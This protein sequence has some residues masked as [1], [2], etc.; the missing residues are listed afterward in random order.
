MKAKKKKNAALTAAAAILAGALCLCILASCGEKVSEGAPEKKKKPPLV[1][2][3]PVETGGIARTVRLPGTIRPAIVANVLSSAEGKITSLD[4]REGDYVTKDAVIGRISPSV[5]EDILN[6][7]RL[8]NDQD[9]NLEFALSQYRE[10]PIVAPT[11]GVVAVRS[12]QPGD[13]VV[14]RQKLLE[15]QSMCATCLHVEI[16]VPE[17]E[18]PFIKKGMAARISPDALP[19]ET[20][21]G[22]VTRVYPRLEEKTRTGTVE[23]GLPAN[24][25]KRLKTGMFARVSFQV[26]QVDDALLV[27]AEAV[28]LTAKGTNAVFTVKEGKAAMRPVKLGLESDGK[29]QILDGITAE[30][31]VVIA[32]NE[33]LKDGGPVRL[34][35]AG[36]K[37][38]GE[39]KQGGAK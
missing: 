2:V 23:V 34:P 5:R 13:M 11:S 7:A 22:S 26:Q 6:A 17:R 31:M 25:A 1:E 30:E 15:V 33:N 32:G 39:K 27:P 37:A 29:V 21:N 3:A 18:M 8:R 12:T 20:F 35:V 9:E 36:K 19:G 38:A 14:Q 24:A 16:P 28:V 4:V 10:I